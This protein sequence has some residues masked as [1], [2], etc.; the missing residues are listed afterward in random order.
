MDTATAHALV[1]FGLGH[2]PSD[3]VPADPVAWLLAQ[4][5]APDPLA[6]AA[7]SS[8]EGLAALRADRK[9]KPP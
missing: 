9:D 2:R 6:G 5:A 3:P 7:P 1:R 8:A 4:L